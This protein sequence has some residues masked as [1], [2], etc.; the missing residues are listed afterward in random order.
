MTTIRVPVL[1][2]V[3]VRSTAAKTRP[4]ARIYFTAPTHI[5]LKTLA[6]RPRVPHR[7][8]RAFSN[9]GVSLEGKFDSNAG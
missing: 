4:P 2:R 5:S 6:T 9:P 7:T 8:P 1:I 3:H